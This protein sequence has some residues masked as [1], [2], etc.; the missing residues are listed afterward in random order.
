ME[1][2]EAKVDG[3]EDLARSSCVHQC[4]KAGVHSVLHRVS[5]ATERARGS[6]Y[7][8][9]RLCGNLSVCGPWGSRAKTEEPQSLKK[10]YWMSPAVGH[11]KSQR[12]IQV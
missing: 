10:E 2:D 8:W 9:T 11:W 12:G 6:G 1:V 4:G 3:C 7:N 5:G